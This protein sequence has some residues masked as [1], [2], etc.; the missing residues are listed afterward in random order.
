MT[1][2][3]CKAELRI[4]T[5]KLGRKSLSHERVVRE[6][7]RGVSREEFDS[8]DAVASLFGGNFEPSKSGSGS[9]DVQQAGGI[10][11]TS[12][13]PEFNLFLLAQR[14]RNFKLHKKRNIGNRDPFWVLDEVSDGEI[15]ECNREF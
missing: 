4:R 2:H 15:I 10:R 6:W 11:N 5:S 3:W 9:K 14:A 8:P 12:L 1:V 7:G 13:P